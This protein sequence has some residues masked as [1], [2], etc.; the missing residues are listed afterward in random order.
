M[1]KTILMLLLCAPLLWIAWRECQ[2]IYNVSSWDPRTSSRGT[3]RTGGEARGPRGDQEQGRCDRRA[4]RGRGQDDRPA[5]SPAGQGSR[6]RAAGIGRPGTCEGAREGSEGGRAGQAGCRRG[7]GEDR[8]G[9]RAPRQRRGS[10]RA[11]LVEEARDLE[12]MLDHYQATQ[13][14]R[15]GAARLG[16][17]RSRMARARQGTPRLRARRLLRSAQSL[18]SRH[19]RGRIIGYAPAPASTRRLMPRTSSGTAPPRGPSP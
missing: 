12:T 5:R 15:P 13:G 14:L 19:A 4:P 3:P 17:S 10:G 11:S 16:A 6:H 18:D 1:R 8:A 2:R 9:S 7:R